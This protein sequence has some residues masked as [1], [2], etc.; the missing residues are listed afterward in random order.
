[1]KHIVQINQ[2]ALTQML[3]SGFE[4]FVIKHGNYK[5]S[6]IEFHGT[7]YGDISINNS[8]KTITH[9]VQFLSADTSAVMKSG[10]VEFN[11]ESTDLKESLAE[12]LGYYQ[13]GMMH[14]HPYLS[15]EMPIEEVR[16][17]GAH[18]SEGDLESF[19]WQLNRYGSDEAYHLEILLTIKQMERFN[20]AKDGRIDE[21]SFE[22]SV[23]N[24]KCFLRAQVFTKDPEDGI[25][26]AETA[27]ECDFLEA[28]Q[29]LEAEFGRIKPKP[30]R[31]RVLEYKPV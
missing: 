27:L 15:D 10:S 6:G 14:S 4:A 29:H 11:L 31:K 13:L 12:Q 19:E 25:A 8:K 3:L 26:L 1:M 21:N 30:G 28:Y 24:S 22:F 7:V 2:Q 5:R 17:R 16:E 18:Y 20:S 23:G 9:K